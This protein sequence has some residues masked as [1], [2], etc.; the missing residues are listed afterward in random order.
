M[1]HSSLIAALSADVA[2]PRPRSFGSELAVA[3]TVGGCISLAV[4][5]LVLGIQPGLDTAAGAGP[6]LMKTAYAG[7][8]ASVALVTSASLARPG[9][10][11]LRYKQATSGIVIAL[12]L[13]A[14]FQLAAAPAAAATTLLLGSSW[15]ACPVFIAG[16][17]LPIFTGIVF[18]MR[19]Q[20][21]VRL[22]EA[23]AV[24]G[25]ASGSIAAVLYALACTE[26]AAPFVLVWYSLGIG[27]STLLGSL[28]GPRL[29]RW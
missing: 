6:F 3:G 28:V 13:I 24:A 19:R 5:V 9:D 15:Q 12:A 20:A 11:R 27:I 8:L 17:S 7:A 18:V 25:L 22:R 14:V 2:S 23:G 29:L 4:I 10:E 21:P 1:D 16:L 26:N